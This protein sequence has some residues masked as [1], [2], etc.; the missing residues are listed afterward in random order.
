MS[1]YVFFTERGG[2][3]DEGRNHS[4]RVR[5]MLLRGRGGVEESEG[6]ERRVRPRGRKKGELIVVGGRSSS[7]P[8]EIKLAF[9]RARRSLDSSELNENLYHLCG[10]KSK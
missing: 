5:E 8:G 7:G 3:G 2:P 9:L 10:R 4:W 6:E 1:L